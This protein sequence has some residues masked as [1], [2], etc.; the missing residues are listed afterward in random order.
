MKKIICLLIILSALLVS[1]SGVKTGKT[2][3][4]CSYGGE[5]KILTDMLPLTDDEY[6]YLYIDG[7]RFTVVS[8]GQNGENEKTL[9]ETTGNAYISELYAN[10]GIIAFF[11]RIMY[12]NNDERVTLK[13]IDTETGE[14]YS[15]YEKVIVYSKADVQ[16]RFIVIEDKS[17]YY[18]TS[19]FVLNR[20][21]V[22]EYTIGDD[23]PSELTSVDLTEN[24]LTYNHSVTSICGGGGKL[25]ISCV[26][27]YTN[28]LALVDMK[29]GECEKKKT[30]ANDVGVVYSTAY[31][32]STGDVLM[33]YS[34]M[35][36]EGRYVAENIG[37]Q[38]FKNDGASVLYQLQDGDSVLRESVTLTDGYALFSIQ[39]QKD[40]SS[41]QTVTGYSFETASGK[42][43]SY[44]N[45]YRC[46]IINGALYTLSIE[47]EKSLTTLNR[48]E[49]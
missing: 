22:M 42:G 35:D 10:D 16:S 12:S 17:V 31:A 23:E 21:R 28:Y 48:S 33:Y 6:A 43:T 27:G 14:V 34:T 7:S 39:N 11:E 18:I 4:V 37:V 25:V 29:T 49:I 20:C 15:P 8:A 44:E 19:S 38:S 13:V 40:A 32:P 45:A 30:L 47:E 24:E 2:K 36:E 46:S 5:D 41:K 3:E 9:H 1:C 26:D